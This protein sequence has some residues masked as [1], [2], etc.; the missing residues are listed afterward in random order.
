M[1]FESMA[2]Y[3]REKQYNKS[4]GDDIDTESPIKSK[5]NPFKIDIPGIIDS[6]ITNALMK[7]LPSSVG[8]LAASLA[9]VLSGTLL[10]TIYKIYKKDKS[11]DIL[12]SLKKNYETFSQGKHPVEELLKKYHSPLFTLLKVLYSGGQTWLSILNKFKTT[13]LKALI[14][15]LDAAEELVG[16]A[17]YDILPHFI[18][19]EENFFKGLASGILGPLA[20]FLEPLKSTVGLVLKIIGKPTLFLFSRLL[21]N[22]WDWIKSKLPFGRSKSWID[23]V[24]KQVT[25]GGLKGL[26][27]PKFIK[28]LMGSLGLGVFWYPLKPYLNLVLKRA[29]Y[30]FEVAKNFLIKLYEKITQLIDVLL[31]KANIGKTGFTEG[32]TRAESEPTTKP[33]T[34]ET[35]GNPK[36]DEAKSPWY[37]KLFLTIENYGKE[38]KAFILELYEK[39]KIQVDNWLGKSN[40]NQSESKAGVT[41]TESKPKPSTSESISSASKSKTEEP[42]WAKTLL[43]KFSKYFSKITSNFVK[44]FKLSSLVARIKG[45]VSKGK[46]LTAGAIRFGKSIFSAVKNAFKIVGTVVKLFSKIFP[47][48][49]KGVLS[50]PGLAIIAIALIALLVYELWKY[51]GPPIKDA[52]KF[53]KEVLTDIKNT[54]CGIGHFFGVEC[55]PTHPTIDL[56]AKKYTKALRPYEP[57]WGKGEP[58]PLTYQPGKHLDPNLFKGAKP[59]EVVP[60][61]VTN[62]KSTTPENKQGKAAFISDMLT[63]LKPLSEKDQKLA[64][65]K[66]AQKT[67]VSLPKNF[68]SLLLSEK[69]K[70]QLLE[71]ILDKMPYS[72]KDVL[73]S[74]GKNANQKPTSPTKAESKPKSTTTEL[75]AWFPYLSK[76]DQIIWKNLI[77]DKI[78]DPEGYFLKPTIEEAKRKLTE[79]KGKPKVTSIQSNLKTA[80]NTV[81]DFIFPSAE[82]AEIKPLSAQPKKLASVVNFNSAVIPTDIK[83]Q[84]QPKPVY[85]PLSVPVSA[86]GGAFISEPVL[87]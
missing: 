26:L 52:W 28:N 86:G 57:P 3:L 62:Q 60:G 84:Q 5:T 47:I 16:R 68:D 72:E 31:G 61:K 80:L 40:T 42:S 54:L 78:P 25:K 27:T 37:S 4:Y 75:P 21:K 34:K 7:V 35:K 83:G 23:V 2:D 56:N 30:Y 19:D 18:E 70:K 85:V 1:I 22:P 17:R 38:I 8:M 51:I 14:G 63:Y 58:K 73:A 10:T 36:S 9:P 29:T 64:L 53:L 49:L 82:A 15:T 65:E 33:E 79:A 45:G 48:I 81:G 77:R 11:L 67:H 13:A 24:L 74:T 6:K 59:A 50:K 66:L 43:F 69:G 32:A 12:K 39:L 44:F 55:G 20:L 46:S 41:Q 87:I 76:K 71:E